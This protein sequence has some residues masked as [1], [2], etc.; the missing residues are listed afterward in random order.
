MV[1]AKS[2]EILLQ[3]EPNS[4]G[5]RITGKHNGRLKVKIST[6]PAEGKANKRLISFIAKTLGVPKSAVRIVKG[7]TSR[8]KTLKVKGLDQKAYN[9]FPALYS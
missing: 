6:P 4:S 7:G 2:V 8:L 9:A 5:D 3:I 1:E